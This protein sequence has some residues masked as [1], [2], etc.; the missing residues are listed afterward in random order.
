MWSA[1]VPGKE[2]VTRLE[3]GL[4]SMFEKLNARLDMLD[5]RAGFSG[6]GRMKSFRVQGSWF[7]RYIG[8]GIPDVKVSWG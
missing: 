1:V 6:L 3:T 4:T 7:R 5:E 2:V 8:F